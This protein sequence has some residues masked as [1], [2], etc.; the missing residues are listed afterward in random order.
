MTND[1]IPF[2]ADGLVDGRLPAD[3]APPELRAAVNLVRAASQPAS[4]E[5]LATMATRVQQ[6]TAEVNAAATAN[7]PAFIDSP[8]RNFMTSTRMTRRALS[9]VA[10]TLLAAGTA[11]AAAGGALPMFEDDSN[12]LVLEGGDT[13]VLDEGSDTT[14]ADDES[15]DSSVPERENHNGS[16]DHFGKCTAWT[17]GSAKDATNPSRVELQVAADAAGLSID[18]YCATVLAAKGAE[19]ES[20][21]DEA[22]DESKDEADDESDDDADHESDDESEDES[23]D[24]S[25]GNSGHGNGHDNSGHGDDESED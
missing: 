5:E 11:A 25:G 18:D 13:S 6:F 16:V 4:A 14:V 17:H 22:D 8:R 2:M 23:G 9:I 21:D 3:A 20:D 15:S 1:H 19:D 24:D 7:T 10:I 12:E